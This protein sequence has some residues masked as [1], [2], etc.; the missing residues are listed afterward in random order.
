MMAT[1]LQF[2]RRPLPNAGGD[3]AGALRNVIVAARPDRP[4]DDEAL[5]LAI[6]AFRQKVERNGRVWGDRQERN[7]RRIIEIMSEAEPRQ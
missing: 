7:V 5:E 2:P 1:I 6:Q 3:L 4:T